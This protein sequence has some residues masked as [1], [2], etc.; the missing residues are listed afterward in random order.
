MVTMVKVM[1]KI[2]HP[3]PRRRP[4]MDGIVVP[5]LT[6]VWR[7]I[8]DIPHL[9]KMHKQHA[10]VMYSVAVCREY[11]TWFTVKACDGLYQLIK[12]MRLD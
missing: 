10:E 7:V 5:I 1:V 2:A 9:A 8:R 6:I 12:S 3:A 11:D 4:L